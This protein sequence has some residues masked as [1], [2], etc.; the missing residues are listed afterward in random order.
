MNE[1]NKTFRTGRL[2]HLLK[3]DFDF[4]CF[5]AIFILEFNPT[6]KA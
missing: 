5:F 4:I 6:G 1:L 2:P 3:T